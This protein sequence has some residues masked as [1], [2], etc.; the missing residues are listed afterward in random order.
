M[1]A[2][3]LPYAL[4]INRCVHVPNA[5]SVFTAALDCSEFEVQADVYL[6]LQYI[7]LLPSPKCKYSG[8]RLLVHS[9]Y[10]FWQI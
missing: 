8:T 7:G 10:Q 9:I 2:Q 3:Q 1:S 4:F 5:S 6:S